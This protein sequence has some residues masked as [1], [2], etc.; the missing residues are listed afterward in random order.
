MVRPARLSPCAHAG[1]RWHRR[2]TRSSCRTTSC[3]RCGRWDADLSGRAVLSCRRQ[4][5]LIGRCGRTH[6][7]A[8][9]RPVTRRSTGYPTQ[10]GGFECAQHMPPV[11]R[12][13]ISTAVCAE[14][15]VCFHW[16]GCVQAARQCQSCGTT[17]TS[18]WRCS[19]TLCNACGLRKGAPKPI[20][21][22]DEKLTLKRDRQVHTAACPRPLLRPSTARPRRRQ[23][24]NSRTYRNKQKEEKARFRHMCVQQVKIA[25][26]PRPRLDTHYH[27]RHQPRRRPRCRPQH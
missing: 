6:F 16:T 26:V 9:V 4:C 15:L 13:S 22:V 3:A 18:K 14:D 5:E 17:K 1:S 20:L 11:P 19:N 25:Q 23:A 21:S 12:P 8:S 7:G 10:L 27:P 2:P 24:L